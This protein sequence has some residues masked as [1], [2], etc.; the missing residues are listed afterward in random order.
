MMTVYL[1]QAGDASQTGASADLQPDEE[2]LFNEL[3]NA[4][5]SDDGQQALEEV[6]KKLMSG[7][8]EILQHLENVA[9]DLETIGRFSSRC[10]SNITG[11]MTQNVEPVGKWNCT[12]SPII[13]MNMVQK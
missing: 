5:G 2:A 6:M 9:Q 8:P 3:F 12:C 11:N 10:L 1:F 7:E 13:T 4:A